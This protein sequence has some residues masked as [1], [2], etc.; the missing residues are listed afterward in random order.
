MLIHICNN[1][2]SSKV[3]SNLIKYISKIL[4]VEQFVFV[5]IRAEG[6][7]GLFSFS[8]THVDIVYRK[9]QGAFIR[10][11]PL[12]KIIFTLLSFIYSLRGK[13]RREASVLAHTLWSDGCVAYLFSLLAGVRYS[14]VVRNT[15]VNW[16]IPK[17]PHYRWLIAKIIARADAVIFV[18]AA[19]RGRFSEDYPHLYK[20]AKIVEVIPNGVE[21]FWMQNLN[22]AECERPETVTFVGRFDKNKNLD[23]LLTA[24]KLVR[25]DINNLRLVLIGGTANDLA[26]LIGSKEVPDWVECLGRIDDKE[27][28]KKYYRSSRVF[29]APSHTETFGLV[30]VEA[31]TQGC[32]FI[33]T[34]GEG[35]DGF[36]DNASYCKAVNSRN[37]S[38]IAAALIALLRQFPRGVSH[39]LFKGRTSE[40]SWA[41]VASRYV[42]LLNMTVE[43]EDIESDC[44]VFK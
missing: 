28:I 3:H 18:S 34:A 24:A 17:L 22:T 41:S 30:Y 35:V 9:C 20:A 43:G 44:R 26:E 27:T 36:F 11:F 6:H 21:D 2:I 8:A 32:P 38:Q 23:G 14:V 13:N 25:N 37:A 4:H 1:F 16:F 5:P 33:Y 29:A 42:H 39:E 19:H 10:F 7:R 12:V 40:F 15:D 31:L